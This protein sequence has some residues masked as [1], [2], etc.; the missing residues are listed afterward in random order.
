MSCQE[1]ACLSC[2][3][4]DSHVFPQCQTF[5]RSIRTTSSSGIMVL[6]R[7]WGLN[8]AYYWNGGIFHKD[9][10]QHSWYNMIYGL[11]ISGACTKGSGYTEQW[12][13]TMMRKLS[14]HEEQGYGAIWTVR[15]TSPLMSS[16]WRA[17][18]QMEFWIRSGTFVAEQQD[19][20]LVVLHLKGRALFGGKG[21]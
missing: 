18:P 2:P 15:I 17:S 10:A 1:P 16:T 4:L 14:C 6:A 8:S 11:W 12:R 13:E 3:R 9:M 5:C 20:Q 7:V 21:C 19:R